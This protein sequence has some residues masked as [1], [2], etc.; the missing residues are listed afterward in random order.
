PGAYKSID[1]VINQQTDL[2]EIAATLKQV[3][4]CKGLNK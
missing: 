1:E 3:C 4:V 2:V